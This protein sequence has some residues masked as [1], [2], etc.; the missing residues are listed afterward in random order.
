MSTKTCQAETTTVVSFDTVD[1]CTSG[2]TSVPTGSPAE[3]A[4]KTYL[5]STFGW[6]PDDI[7]LE[8][9]EPG[10]YVILFDTAS[11]RFIREC[12]VAEATTEA[13]KETVQTELNKYIKRDQIREFD[14]NEIYSHYNIT[15]IGTFAFDE[16]TSLTTVAIP[17]SVTAIGNYAFWECTS[18]TTVAIPDSVTAIGTNAFDECTSLTTIAIPDSVTTIG[19]YAFHGCISL[20]TIAIPDSVTDISRGAFRECTSLTTVA[21]PDSVTAIGEYAFEGCTSLT[22]IAIPDSVT[23][24]CDT[25]FWECTSLIR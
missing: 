3:G 2:T 4:L 10:K 15:T 1:G 23:A 11:T 19:G 21:I 16:C 20:T 7:V 17:D 24:I 18:L 8:M 14:L 6:R 22:T 9:Y 25:A 13:D 5:Q 12:S